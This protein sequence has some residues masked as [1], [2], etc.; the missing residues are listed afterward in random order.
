MTSPL[1]ASTPPLQSG[2]LPAE[3]GHEVCWQT[4]GTPSCPAILLLHG[5]PGSGTSERMP[6][7]FDPAHWHIVTM[8]QRGA[9]RSRPHA[10]T[11]L[12]ALVN[13]TT[14]HLVADIERLRTALN[15]ESWTVYGSSWGATLAQAYAHAH[16]DRVAGLILAAVTSTSQAE[17]DNLYGG[18]GAYLPEAFDAFQAAAPEGEPGVGMAKAY[19]QRLTCGDAKIEAAAALAWCRWEEAVLQVDPRA[20]PTGRFE[21]PV[22]RLGFARIVTHYF[23]HLAWLEPPLLHRAP[24]L[25]DLP[26]T[27]INSRL[28]LS[29]PLST[30]WQLHQALPGSRLIIIPGS[31]HGTLYGPLAKAVV[32]AGRHHQALAD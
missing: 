26:T 19:A 24:A 7:L 28:D 12:R 5:G 11:D 9:G 15:I 22:F 20:E 23:S 16:R 1:F 27:L 2:W 3:G 4:F 8:D 21:D 17:L 14:N 18:A 30:A 32:E 31:L 29:C 10:G 6:R 25:N 13:N